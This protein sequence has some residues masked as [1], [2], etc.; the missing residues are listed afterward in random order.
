MFFVNKREKKISFRKLIYEDKNENKR[1][2][3]HSILSL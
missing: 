2:K 3:F 1:K